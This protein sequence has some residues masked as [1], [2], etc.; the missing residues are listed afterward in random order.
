MA[1]NVFS[2]SAVMACC[3]VLWEGFALAFCLLTSVEMQRSVGKL[4]E[5]LLCV[6][7]IFLLVK[8]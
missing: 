1:A 4:V 8:S 5:R 6:P 2:M 7:V 3:S